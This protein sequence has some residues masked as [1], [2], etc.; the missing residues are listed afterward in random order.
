MYPSLLDAVQSAHG[1]PRASGSDVH[2]PGCTGLSWIAKRYLIVLETCPN[3]THLSVGLASKPPAS[4][5]KPAVAE[6]RDRQA[7]PEPDKW[8]REG[9]LLLDPVKL[10]DFVGGAFAELPGRLF[11][12][13][14]DVFDQTHC[15]VTDDGTSSQLELRFGVQKGRIT[16]LSWKAF[17]FSRKNGRV[18]HDLLRRIE[19]AL[20]CGE[21]DRHRYKEKTNSDG[22]SFR[23]VLISCK[24]VEYE[25]RAGL[26]YFKGTNNS[27]DVTVFSRR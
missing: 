14:E 16:H 7:D 5:A 4:A 10:S 24:T 3:A 20:P 13:C 22:D 19:R 26:Y 17:S 25:Y 8:P 18:T 27:A 12:D 15:A 21:S 9:S 11:A 6:E 23:E 1:K 2:K